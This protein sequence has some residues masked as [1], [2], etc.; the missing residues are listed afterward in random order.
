MPQSDLDR[1]SRGHPRV[2]WIHCNYSPSRLKRCTALA[3]RFIQRTGL[4][5]T[6]RM[7]VVENSNAKAPSDPGPRWERMCGSNFAR[8]F[9]AWSEGWE[10]ARRNNEIYDIVILSN[11]TFP[12]HQPYA[13]LLEPLLRLKI[14]RLLHTDIPWALGV[15]ERGFNY[16]EFQ[17]YITSFLLILGPGAVGPALSR[18]IEI[19][20]GCG[21]E[22]DVSAGRVIWSTDP[23]YQQRMNQWLLEPGGK[24]WYGARRLDEQS[25]PD[26]R[27]KAQCMLL[28]HGVSRRLLTA[29]VR[30]VSCFDLRWPLGRLARIAYRV[31]E[32]ADRRRRAGSTV[33]HPIEK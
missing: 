11:D 31:W 12:Y 15:V 4:D 17:E 25:W 33:S 24:G 3:E 29:G 23:I 28:E 8:E 9:S 19:P 13:W 21:L 30:L 26:L 22:S 27:A 14:K 2:L 20:E 18:L 5:I 1:R 10:F 6:S 16:R 7:I 32:I